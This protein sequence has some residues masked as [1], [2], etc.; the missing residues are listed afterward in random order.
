MEELQ[1]QA[2]DLTAEINKA[3]EQLHTADL[4]AE[5]QKLQAQSLAPDFWNDNL[6]AQAV[7]KQIS[8]L[9]GRVKPWRDLER[10]AGEVSELA[11]LNDASLQTDLAKQLEQLQTKLESLKS[12]LK[13]SGPYDDYDAIV[14]LH[15]GAGG[16]D[17]QDWRKCCCACTSAGPKPTT[18]K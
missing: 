17:A 14:S 8:K 4:E 13:L 5:L 7:T 1:K 9:E 6:A 12:Q 11:A 3:L 15:A 18:C 10:E 2:S 16:T